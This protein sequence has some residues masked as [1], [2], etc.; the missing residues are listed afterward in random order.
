LTKKNSQNVTL[1]LQHPYFATLL[2]NEKEKVE[3]EKQKKMKR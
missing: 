1:A 2:S 3:E